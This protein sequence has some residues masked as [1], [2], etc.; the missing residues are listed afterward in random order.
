MRTIS[1][2]L[3]DVEEIVVAEEQGEYKPLVAAVA[4]ATDFESPLFVLRW[5]LTPEER[6][7]LIDGEDL[8]TTHLTFGHAFQP[9]TT[10]VGKPDWLPPLA[11]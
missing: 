8:W 6:Q 9:L 4:Y 1:P 5:R 3:K 10:D 2:N 11:G 7:R